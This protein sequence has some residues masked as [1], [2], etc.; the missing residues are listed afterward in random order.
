[1]TAPRLPL[2]RPVAPPVIHQGERERL[3]DERKELLDELAIL[4]RHSRLRPGLEHRLVK[5]TARLL[6]FGQVIDVVMPDRADLS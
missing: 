6:S 1:M 2:L 3:A 5:V 4:P